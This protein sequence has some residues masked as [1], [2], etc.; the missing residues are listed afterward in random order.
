MRRLEVSTHS[1]EE[2]EELGRRLGRAIAGPV[3]VAL[4]GALG[5]GKT[6]LARGLAE[7]LGVDPAEVASPTFLYLVHYPEARLPLAHADLY[8][9]AGLDAVALRETLLAIGLEDAIEEGVAVVEWWA[10]YRG[11]SPQAV[12]RVELSIEQAEDRRIVL[13]FDGPEAE[14]IAG[15]GLGETPTFSSKQSDAPAGAGPR[16]R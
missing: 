3:V 16:N 7:G 10:N 2:T 8:R 15:S 9:L 5:A 4:D 11:P 14:R 12:I 13:E 6:C 1:S